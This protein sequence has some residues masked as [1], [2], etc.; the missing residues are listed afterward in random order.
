VGQGTGAGAAIC[1]KA[2]VALHGDE[3]EVLWEGT[4]AVDGESPLCPLCKGRLAV[5]T[6][7]CLFS[8]VLSTALALHTPHF[9][10]CTLL[11]LHTHCPA[12]SLPF[13]IEH[14]PRNSL[15]CVSSPVP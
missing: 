2:V 14:I 4:Q 1:S 10:T 6:R 15:R 7:L 11:A 9:L 8:T 5:S 13:S 3:L 12:H